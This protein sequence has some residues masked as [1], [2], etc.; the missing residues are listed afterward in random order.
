MAHY[1][2]PA[3]RLDLVMSFT[4]RDQPEE[5]STVFHFKG[6]APSGDTAWKALSDKVITALRPVVSASVTFVRAYGYAAN[7]IG[8]EFVN[9]YATPGPPLAGTLS[10]TGLIACSGDTAFQGRLLSDKLT[11]NG[12]HVYKRNYFHDA[13]I[14]AAG[15][16]DRLAPVQQAAL[17]TF[18]TSYAQATIDPVFDACLPDLTN[19]HTP[20]VDQWLTTRTLHRRG[21]RKINQP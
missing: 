13:H 9:D 12:K 7:E 6:P 4:Y 16:R 2:Q 3:P 11:I 15:D 18:L 1:T 20:H 10:T 14:D 8:A 19:C 21:K 5:F 17:T